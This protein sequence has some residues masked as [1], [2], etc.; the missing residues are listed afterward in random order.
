MANVFFFLGDM[1]SK[2]MQWDWMNADSAIVEW[3]AGINYNI[4]NWLMLRSVDFNDKGGCDVWVS[5]VGDDAEDDEIDEDDDNF[6]PI[7]FKKKSDS[8]SK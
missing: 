7:T 8:D 6:T 2:P 5:R 3:I 4:Y 1:V